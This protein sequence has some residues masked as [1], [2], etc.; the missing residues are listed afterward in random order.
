MKVKLIKLCERD[1]P[2]VT[3]EERE[4]VG[5]VFEA[6]KYHCEYDRDERY[7]D[8]YA[9]NLGDGIWFVPAFCCEEVEETINV[10]NA[11]EPQQMRFKNEILL[12]E[13]G[14]VDVDHIEN[15]LGISCIVYRQNSRKP[16]WLGN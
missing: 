3:D 15:E 14:S 8:M 16:E 12:V 10:S 11:Q 13:D 5:K 4:R 1:E 6:L 7:H 9:L 2:Y